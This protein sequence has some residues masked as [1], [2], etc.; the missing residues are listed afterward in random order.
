MS[1][2]AVRAWADAMSAGLARLMP[3]FEATFGF[4]PTDNHVALSGADA[5][6]P[7]V[8][9]RKLPEPLAEFYRVVA[10][11]WLMDVHNGFRI[12]PVRSVTEESDAFPTRIVGALAGEVFVFGSN[13]GGD[14]ILMMADGRVHE[15]GGGS[16]M[17]PE[18]DVDECNIRTS[19]PDL[20]AFLDH[21]LAYLHEHLEHV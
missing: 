10:E 1:E 19:F 20:Q 21:V 6:P 2:Q 3:V 4:E 18:Y 12:E 17:Y 7:A 14:L 13:G 11:A 15:V 9:G 8:G 16:F 5:G